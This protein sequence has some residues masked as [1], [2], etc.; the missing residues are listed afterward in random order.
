MGIEIERKFLVNGDGWRRDIQ[1][2]SEYRQGYLVLGGPTSVR[3]RVADD[4][5]NLNIKSGKLSIRRLEYEYEIPMEEAVE[6][7]DNLCTGSVVEKTRHFVRHGG[8]TWEIDVFAGDNQGLVVAE[9]ELQ[10]E[11]E[12]FER[13]DWLGKEVSVDARYYN[14]SLSTHPYRE[15]GE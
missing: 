8:H 7:L 2:S 1:R 6:M 15:W 10:D 12:A 11:Q 5:A 13:P 14:V 3:V 4:R 9:I